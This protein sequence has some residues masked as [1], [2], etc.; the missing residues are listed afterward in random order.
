M[1][2]GKDDALT[3]SAGRIA[4]GRAQDWDA[5]LDGSPELAAGREALGRVARIAGAWRAV[6]NQPPED[7]AVGDAVLFRWV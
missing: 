2:T 5:A 7:E 6:G 1:S 4:D 3:E